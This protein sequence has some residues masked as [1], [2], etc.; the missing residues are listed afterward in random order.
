[1]KAYIDEHKSRPSSASKDK[2]IKTLGKWIRYSSNKLQKESNIMKDEAIRLQWE[3]FVNDA[4]YKK[5]LM[6]DKETWYDKLS[7]VKAYMDE[8]KSRPNPK[9]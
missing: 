2:A 1:M 6:S 7:K 4:R 8:H 3:E 9:K 5:Y